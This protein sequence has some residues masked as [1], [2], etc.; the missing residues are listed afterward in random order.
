MSD[1]KTTSPRF[2]IETLRPCRLCGATREVK[3]YTP[4]PS[5]SQVILGCEKEAVTTADTNESDELHAPPVGKLS[6][7]RGLCFRCM[8]ERE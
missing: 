6:V 8:G 7:M 4:H 5:L 2:R 1:T 3:V